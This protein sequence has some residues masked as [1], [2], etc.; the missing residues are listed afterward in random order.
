M[1]RNLFRNRF[2]RMG[3]ETVGLRRRR[4]MPKPKPETIMRNKER[5][6]LKSINI[7]SAD[8]TGEK[9]MHPWADQKRIRGLVTAYQE[10]CNNT[11]HA[12]KITEAERK[13]IA[14]KGRE[15][16]LLGVRHTAAL[17]V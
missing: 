8:Y 2:I 10:L 9:Q 13:E 11:R 14:K 5:K 12:K 3:E 7:Y 16:A 17:P 6:R 1:L 15:M 4:G